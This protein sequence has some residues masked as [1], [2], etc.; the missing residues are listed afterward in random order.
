[1]VLRGTLTCCLGLGSTSEFQLEGL[2]QKSHRFEFNETQPSLHILYAL[3]L[4]D[5]Y[6][7]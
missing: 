5:L 2:G 6:F 7:W 3:R 4:P 1:M